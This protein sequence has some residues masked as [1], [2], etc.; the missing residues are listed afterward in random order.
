MA[1]I[2][3]LECFFETDLGEAPVALDWSACGQWLAVI[4]VDSEVLVVDAKTGTVIKNWK[5]HDEG[6]LALAW[7]P[8]LPIFASSCQNGFVK[9]WEIDDQH[10]IEQVSE[11]ALQSESDNPWIEL[12]KWRRDGKQLAIASGNSVKLSSAQGDVETSLPF[13]GGTIGAMAWHPKGSLLGI[14]GYGGILIYNALDPVAKPIELNWKGSLLSLSWSPD[15]KFIVAGCQDNTV[16]VWRLRSRQDS[17]MSGFAY[18]PL[19]LTWSNGGKRLLTGGTKDLVIWSFNRKGAEEGAP[20]ARSFHDHAIC[21]IGV[22][23]NGKGIASGCRNGHIAVWESVN[24]VK[25]RVSTTLDSRVE[26]LQWS[27]V[28]KSKTLAASSRHG[29]LYLF[30]ASKFI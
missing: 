12:I 7:H 14:A 11:I 15:G 4:N 29:S 25:P 5:A 10:S 30:D 17:L 16:H 22:A 18:K 13:P 8:R 28:K 26:H 27:P 21:A 2:Q 6:A 1:D 9:L 20:D 23:S 19:Q 3:T 24:D